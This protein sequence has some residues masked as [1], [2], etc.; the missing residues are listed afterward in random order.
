VTRIPLNREITG[1]LVFLGTGTSVGVPMIGCGCPV[2]TSSDPHN[3][4]SRCSL[5][6]GLP[7]GNLL[8][9]TS[10]D[11]R[12]QLVREQIGIIH[13]ALFTHEHADHVMGFDDLRLF[14]FYLGHPVP[15][16][17]E[18]VVERRIRRS[19]DY[20][21]DD[22][23][24]THAGA[25]PKVSFQRINLAPFHLLGMRV[26]P[27]RLLHGRFEVL[28]FRF[29]DVAYCTDTNRIPPE[30]L[31]L[32]E[33]LDVLILGALRHSPHPAHYSLDEAVAVAEQLQ[34]KRTLFTHVSHEMEYA[35]TN[36]YLP[37]GMELAHDALRLPLRP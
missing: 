28:G 17:C 35:A 4:R 37:R 8:V 7:E 3:R 2:C 36:A 11:L 29:G 12:M 31:A 13:A 9:D 14:Q 26:V 22:R 15:V 6:L 5:A 32:L 10:P 27:L 24:Q 21:F 30:S 25:V 19:F 18:E 1:Q 33:G 16:Y 23:P 34:P 20:A